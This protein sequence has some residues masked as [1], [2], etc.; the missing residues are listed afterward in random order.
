MLDEIERFVDAVYDF[1]T[2]VEDVA[3]SDSEDAGE[4][5]N[6]LREALAAF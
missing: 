4:L 5:K 1:C 3:N 2:N 6:M